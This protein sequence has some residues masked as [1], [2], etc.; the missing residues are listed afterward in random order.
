MV[1][2]KHV[3]GKEMSKCVFV[4]VRGAGSMHNDH[5]V[6]EG[7]QRRRSQEHRIQVHMCQV[8]VYNGEKNGIQLCVCVRACVHVRMHAHAH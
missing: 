7:I 8:R 3:E 5:A 4:C 6:F 2:A 1:C